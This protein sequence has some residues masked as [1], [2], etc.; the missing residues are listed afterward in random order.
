MIANDHAPSQ[1]CILICTLGIEC[2]EK[3]CSPQ[4]DAVVDDDSSILEPI[5]Y[6]YVHHDIATCDALTWPEKCNC[7]AKDKDWAISYTK[8][9]YT[10][11]Y[12]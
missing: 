7:Y 1:M 8:H 4:N 2:I 6:Y 11:Y 12:F 3:F 10:L 9:I 5:W